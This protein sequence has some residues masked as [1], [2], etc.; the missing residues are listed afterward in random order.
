MTAAFD[1]ERFLARLGAR[2]LGPSAQVLDSVGSTNDAAWE[3]FGAGAAWGTVVIADQ[4]TRGRGRL[5][6]AWHTAPGSGLALS[7]LLHPAP[8]AGGALPL[9]AGVAVAQAL[10]RLGARPALEW[11]N[12][13]MLD[14]RKVAGLLCESRR[15]GGVEAVV[16]GL[17]VNVL[18][19]EPDLP[20]ELRASATSLAIAGIATDRETVAASFLD[21]LEPW[22]E[23]LPRD[24]VAKALGAWRTRARFWGA[25][26]VVR[27]AGGQE[28]AGIARG[29]DPGGAL[30]LDGDDGREH[31]VLAGEVRVA[32][33]AER[34]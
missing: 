22:L 3:A 16:I 13:V 30:V 1:R 9:I 17:G 19:A 12:D 26:V 21:A 31:V 5:G 28:I 25:R 8:D 7:L 24:G 6:H 18:Q 27:G 15:G 4:Q 14:G 23:A 29:L 10:E 32:A 11:P 33:G 20:L 34:G 2:T